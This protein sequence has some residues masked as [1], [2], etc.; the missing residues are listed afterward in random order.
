M[1]KVKNWSADKQLAAKIKR[2]L[3]E[4]ARGVEA[5]QLNDAQISA[6][7]L[8][9]ERINPFL[10]VASVIP[11]DFFQPV[12]SVRRVYVAEADDVTAPDR[13]EVTPE[14]RAEELKK[15]AAQRLAAAAGSINPG[16]PV[17]L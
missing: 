6:G 2:R 13:P 4:H 7:R 10:K 3:G 9:L 5:V 16:A 12:T 15:L 8:I 17:D 14:Q 11:D 1:A